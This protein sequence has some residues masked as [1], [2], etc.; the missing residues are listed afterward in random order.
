ML[1]WMKGNEAG[2]AGKTRILVNLELPDT[3]YLFPLFR[4]LQGA[5]APRDA[6]SR[7]CDARL[8]ERFVWHPR[9]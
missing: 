7:V 8:Q 3:Y 5:G 6:R 1:D 9:Y 2:A 4:H